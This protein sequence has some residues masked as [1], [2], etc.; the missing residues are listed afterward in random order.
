MCRNLQS[1]THRKGRTHECVILLS[2]VSL[3]YPMCR[4]PDLGSVPLFV[5][6]GVE[7]RRKEGDPQTRPV[8]FLSHRTLKIWLYNYIKSVKAKCDGECGQLWTTLIYG[9]CR[10]FKSLAWLYSI[11]SPSLADSFYKESSSFCAQLKA[12]ALVMSVFLD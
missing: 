12:S 4:W 8:T 6:T 2:Y 7:R 1:P 10:S 5:Y 9:S 3:S 11:L